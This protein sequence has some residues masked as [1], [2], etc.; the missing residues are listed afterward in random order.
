LG[1]VLGNPHYLPDKSLLIRALAMASFLRTL[2]LACS[3]GLVLAST[4]CNWYESQDQTCS[5]EKTGSGSMTVSGTCITIISSDGNGAGEKT[6]YMKLTCSGNSWKAE[7]YTTD[8]SS[9]LEANRDYTFPEQ[10]TGKCMSFT[11][12]GNKVGNA[13]CSSFDLCSGSAQFSCLK[14]AVKEDWCESSCVD[15]NPGPDDCY[16]QDLGKADAQQKRLPRLF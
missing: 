8:C 9:T 6:E 2:F 7:R 3:M 10:T 5:G 1:Q 11:N 13:K 15:E 16:D 4:N 14:D 12:S